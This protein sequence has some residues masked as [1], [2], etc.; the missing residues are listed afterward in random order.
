[1]ELLE[2]TSQLAALEEAYTEATSN[3][4]A[5]VV[6]K[7]EAGGAKTALVN[8]FASERGGG[9]QFWGLCDDLLTPRPLGRIRD[10]AAQVVGKLRGVIA[11][12]SVAEVLEALIEE[13]DAPPRPALLIIE[14]AHW[15]DEATLDVLQ[16]L[17][18]RVDRVRAALRP[19]ALG[20][21][22]RPSTQLRS[23]W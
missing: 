10:A 14:D 17:G 6:V 23:G 8:H 18:R 19:I 13:L 3:V 16:F 11:S 21:W 15:A 12:G 1:M 5:V 20:S 7:A 9:R 22:Y 2:R 4:G